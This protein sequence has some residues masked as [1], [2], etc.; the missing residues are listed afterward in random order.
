MA[1]GAGA[2]TVWAAAA[3][4]CLPGCGLSHIKFL[5]VNL[6]ILQPRLRPLKAWMVAPKSTNNPF[7]LDADSST[8]Q[9]KV[10][11][12]QVMT[13]TSAIYGARSASL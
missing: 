4:H 5:K 8:Q 11:R 10:W 12:N 7:G 1:G 9:G 2:T 6:Q 3:G 13:I